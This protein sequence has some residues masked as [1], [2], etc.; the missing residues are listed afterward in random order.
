VPLA[1]V[2]AKVMTGRTLEELGIKEVVPSHVAVKESVFPFVKFEEVDTILGPEMRSTGEVMGIDDSF[3]RAYVKAQLAAGVELPGGGTAFLS[4]RDA[5]KTA[6]VGLARRLAGLGFDLIAT[7]GTAKHLSDQG[8]PC[9]G[10]NKVLEGRPHCVDAM[11]NGE[12]DFVVN[13]T[14][15][16]QAILDSQSLR[17]GA[18]RNGIAY[19]TTIRGADAAIEAIALAR[20]EGLRVAPLQSYQ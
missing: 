15:G 6:L 3:V 16:V 19:F 7:H 20:R 17:R 9:R 12:I 10:V 2:A 1:K 8:I 18:L 11:D 13:T 4:V 5:D 14:E